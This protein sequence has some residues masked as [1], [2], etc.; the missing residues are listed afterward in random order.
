MPSPLK[1]V[2]LVQTLMLAN[3]V[4]PAEME[5]LPAKLRFTL[6]TIDLPEPEIA[7]AHALKMM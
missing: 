7:E 5:L 4:E 1:H 2:R 6:P 3:A